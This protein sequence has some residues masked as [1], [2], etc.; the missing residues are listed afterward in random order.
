LGCSDS[1]FS[2]RIRTNQQL[3]LFATFAPLAVQYNLPRPTAEFTENGSRPKWVKDK[4]NGGQERY[5]NDSNGLK[6]PVGKPW[7]GIYRDLGG[8]L[9]FQVALVGIKEVPADSSRA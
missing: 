1:G 5:P 4:T 3:S 7:V 6:N 2:S 9:A 8:E